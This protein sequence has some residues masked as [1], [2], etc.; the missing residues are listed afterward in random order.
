L[1]PTEGLARKQA[2]EA[3]GL[4]RREGFSLTRAASRADTTPAAVLRHAG[5]ALVRSP[6]GRYQPTPDDRLFRP[7]R[8]LTTEGEVELDLPNS[9]DA[10]LVGRHWAA[11]G[12][13]LE[14]S[15]ERTLE[16]FRGCRVGGF[17]LETDPDVIEELA[18]RGELRF[19][20]IYRS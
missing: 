7:L 18:R 13:L 2:L 16:G 14:K 1:R 17:V 6:G 15:D 12:L 8:A 20:D 5:A 10:S 11:I 9:R 19:E 4:M 3:V